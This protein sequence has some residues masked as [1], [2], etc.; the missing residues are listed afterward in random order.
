MTE[1]HADS[2]TEQATSAEPEIT[3]PFAAAVY[4]PGTR[5]SAELARFIE[6]LKA[7]G[8]SLGGLVQEEV[9]HP[10]GS[11]DRI[12]TVD[13]ATGQRIVIN[14]QTEQN[15]INHNCSLD[16]SALTETTVAIR[17]AIDRGA[18]LVIIEK[19]GAQETTGGGL[20]DDIL[21]VIAEGVPL[22]VAVPEPSLDAW[23]ERTGGMG[24]RLAYSEHDFQA[25][26]AALRDA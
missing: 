13:I 12:D 2:A 8:V 25:W 15:R 1:P 19:F 10:D 11:R 22:L 3:A 23:H 26:W 17:Q 16:V 9:F 20:A 7:D 4:A 24:A 6:A 18:E 14:K 5:D 21:Q